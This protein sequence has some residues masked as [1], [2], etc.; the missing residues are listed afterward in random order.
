MSQ[1]VRTVQRLGD[2][3]L[4]LGLLS[5]ALLFQLPAALAQTGKKTIMKQAAPATTA[6][7]TPELKRQ[8]G[9]SLNAFTLDF[10]RAVNRPGPGNLFVSPYSIA[11]ALS[12][13][14]AG[15]RG[16]TQAELTRTPHLDREIGR[17]HV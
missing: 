16:N 11:T 1:T 17:A 3:G 8:L 5:A 12:M 14:S 7:P 13:T 4:A 9:A 15:A 2:G 10:Y 6:V